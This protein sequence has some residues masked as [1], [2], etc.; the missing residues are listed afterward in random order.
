MGIFA[1][2]NRTYAAPFA[3]VWDAAVALNKAGQLG[4][5]RTV[6]V[7]PEL[8]SAYHTT[9][10]VYAAGN[11]VAQQEQFAMNF[12]LDRSAEGWVRDLAKLKTQVGE[13]DTSAPIAASGALAGDFTW[14]CA[15]GRLKGSLELAPTRPPLIQ[16]ITY[17]VTTP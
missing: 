2:A 6:A 7:S 9:A 8:E 11:L 17:T 4:S 10:A 3:P 5:E 1:F 13:C 16:E 12:F 14:R 15:H